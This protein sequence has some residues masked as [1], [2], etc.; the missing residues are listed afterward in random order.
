VVAMGEEK[1]EEADKF[2]DAEGVQC[3][4]EAEL[5]AERASA[6]E[7]CAKNIAA[8]QAE[9]CQLA[10]QAW[11]DGNAR[12]CKAF[13]ESIVAQPA[14]AG[15]LSEICST[16]RAQ[17]GENASMQQT[18]SSIHIAERHRAD[19][20]EPMAAPATISPDDVA[21][22]KAAMIQSLPAMVFSDKPDAPSRIASLQ[23]FESIYSDTSSAGAA[24]LRELQTCE[25]AVGA[26]SSSATTSIEQL[27]TNLQDA[28]SAGLLAASPVLERGTAM[29]VTLV[30]RRA[31]GVHIA[32][33]L[34]LVDEQRAAVEPAFEPALRADA[35]STAL[36]EALGRLREGIGSAEQDALA[37]ER[38]TARRALIG[39][40]EA[41]QRSEAE[42]AHGGL[43]AAHAVVQV[44]LEDLRSAQEAASRIE[45]ETRALFPSVS[46][47]PPPAPPA[48]GAAEEDEDE[49]KAPGP[50][51]PS[52]EDWALFDVPSAE[53]AEAATKRQLLERLQAA[54]VSFQQQCNLDA[55]VKAV[56]KRTTKPGMV[57]H[58]RAATALAIAARMPA[59]QQQGEAHVADGGGG[60][61][62]ADTVQEFDEPQAGVDDGTFDDDMA[63]QCAAADRRADA[64][65]ALLAQLSSAAATLEHCAEGLPHLQKYEVSPP[66]AKAL[67][68]AVK[69]VKR[70]KVGLQRA[71]QDYELE[72][73]DDADEAELQALRTCIGDADERRRAA[74][75]CL[76]TLRELALQMVAHYP[77]IT[78]V[79]AR[80]IPADL[81]S[82]WLPH[83]QL[84]DF[85]DTQ[86]IA[87]GRHRIH[88]VDSGDGGQQ[89]VLKEFPC[90]GGQLKYFLRELQ[91]LH[92]V[93]HPCV[94]EIEAIFNDSERKSFFV[95]MPF[96]PGGNLDDFIKARVAEGAM[97]GSDARLLLQ[98]ALQGVEYLHALGIVHADLKPANILVDSDGMPRLTDFET[99]RTVGG[100]DLSPSLT[101]GGGTRGFEAPELRDGS[102][103]PTT[104]SDIFAF[105]K[106]LEKASE[107]M[108]AMPGETG[109]E[110]LSDL[111]SQLAHE[112]G[113][114]RPTAA[115]ALQH[116]YFTTDA[117]R[118]LSAAEAEKEEAR[119]ERDHL[120]GR[121][122]E[123]HQEQ[124]ELQR[125]SAE[126]AQRR[127]KLEVKREKLDAAQ[128]M[129]REQLAA[130]ECKLQD[131]RHAVAQ[132]LAKLKRQAAANGGGARG[133]GGD[134]ESRCAYTKD[135]AS[136]LEQA[137]PDLQAPNFNSNH[138]RCYCDRCWGAADGRMLETDN[139]HHAP[140]VVPV[141]WTRFALEV[142]LG[143]AAQ[144][145]IFNA[146]AVSFHGASP[147]VVTSIITEGAFKLPGD[148]LFNGT[149]L[150]AKNSAGRENREFFT[151]PTICY[152]GL[153]FYAEPCPYRAADGRTRYGQAVL[154]C[155][156]DPASF[157][158]QGQTMK[159]EDHEQLCHTWRDVRTVE[160]ISK[161]TGNIMPYGIVIR[162]FACGDEPPVFFR[163]PIDHDDM[164]PWKK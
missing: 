152:A 157:E 42:A 96:C 34:T 134:C 51:V 29:L 123:V 24:R 1:Q 30:Q 62:G 72:A 55:P 3:C 147:L 106:T 122:Q 89:S 47:V 127:A 85:G 78:A 77:E 161:Q 4:T 71:R 140:Y 8:L 64:H 36:K 12:A 132:Q 65:A 19:Q 160:R 102:A 145:D 128:Q 74:E 113:G 9:A 37:G 70:A 109:L 135:C 48:Q 73:G 118:L 159:F 104:A 20:L 129:A 84:S 11:R 79:V 26:A 52:S 98:R 107:A 137:F 86:A 103:E 92:A 111:F 158:T 32:A 28:S 69:L 10:E 38:D 76:R 54:P 88:K 100:D 43:D 154:Q 121:L 95:Q 83:R 87:G 133:R 44:A 115:E 94:M 93:R 56:L 114:S 25:S 80:D 143:R 153:G 149:V 14:L 101:K 163:S 59:Q 119:R 33:L 41:M 50:A 148:I 139:E 105:G 68:A 39:A 112:N 108:A 13:R 150:K 22:A 156:Q 16:F 81:Q 15:G 2:A 131:E 126:L 49:S 21:E 82:L 23:A 142:P 53:W 5:L 146:W 35:A 162:T 6:M 18:A 17:L 7:S 27:E 31:T 99:S 141:G 58:M 97:S 155:R 125:Q 144:H 60:G 45:A 117:A 67:A 46:A 138:D 151:S 75:A 90:E 120:N 91:R 66:D 40:M 124:R 63:Q 61:A 116:R 130:D 164:V 110:A 57:Q 136:F